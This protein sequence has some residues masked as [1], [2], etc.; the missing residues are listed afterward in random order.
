MSLVTNKALK[1]LLKLIIP[2]Y[3]STFGAR[4]VKDIYNYVKHMALWVIV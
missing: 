3:N 4:K 2:Y 1:V